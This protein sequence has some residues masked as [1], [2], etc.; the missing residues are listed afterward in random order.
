MRKKATSDQ[1][2]APRKNNDLFQKR[3]MQIVKKATKLFMKKGYAQTS[4]REISKATGIDI[5]NL[6]YFIKSKEEILFRVFE[7]I[8]GPEIELFEKQGIMSIDDPLEQL[9]TV[10]RELLDFGYDYGEEILLLYRESKVLPKS[11]RKI[12]LSR[13]S[14]FVAQ[15]EDILKKGLERKVFSFEDTSF[16]ANMIVYELSLHP[17]RSWNLKTY[18]KGELINLLEKHVMKAVMI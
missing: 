4:M 15:I 2:S 8:H 16:T 10:I 11:L 12:I 5:S 17:L 6:Y 13:E 1:E 3:Q 14:H 18:S 7:M 9:R